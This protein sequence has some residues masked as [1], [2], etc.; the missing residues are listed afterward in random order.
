MTFKC[1]IAD[2]EKPARDLL[3]AYAGQLEY[4][5]VVQTCKNG[6]ETINAL[7]NSSLDILF[8]DIQM[9]RLKGTEVVPLI[10]D[11][12]PVVVF[13]TAYDQYA[14]EAFNLD[15]VDYL[16]KPFGFDRFV[17]AVDKAVSAVRSIRQI[18]PAEASDFMMVKSEYK[19]VRVNLED[20][21]Y[22]E[23]LREYV[24]IYT[25][26]SDV[27]TLDTMKRLDSVLPDNTFCRIHKSY[28]VALPKIRSI[29]GNQVEIGGKLL[30]VGRSYKSNLMEALRLDPGLKS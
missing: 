29:Q 7:R 8:L 11:N 30:P 25:D 15:G 2:D 10:R 22:I 9:P 5:Q 28:I 19:Q 21:T 27:L 14:V 16:L 6:V 18:R 24:R 26:S 1:L 23:A 17:Q 13:T 20:I 3:E 4:L 12:L